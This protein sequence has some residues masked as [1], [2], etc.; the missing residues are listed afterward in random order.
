MSNNHIYCI[1]GSA[2]YRNGKPIGGK[3]VWRMNINDP[4]F[5]WKEVAPLSDERFL[6][7]G[8]LF[9]EV[10]TVAG[11]GG[12]KPYM[13][14]AEFYQASIYEWKMDIRFKRLE[15]AAHW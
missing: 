4:T 15:A 13:S 6:M 3:N 10:L 9:C 7:G 5:Q 12:K 14:S 2:N 8:T 1:G 11:G